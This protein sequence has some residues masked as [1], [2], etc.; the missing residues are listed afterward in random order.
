MPRPRNSATVA[1][2]ASVA[3]VFGALFA[4][5]YTI[6]T[7]AMAQQPLIPLEVRP[8]QSPASFEVIEAHGAGP[9]EIWCAAADHAR[10]NL[11]ASAPQRIYVAEPLGQSQTQTGHQKAQRAVTFTLIAPDTAP[12]QAQVFLACVWRF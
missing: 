9:S 4:L 8:A 7:P 6:G 2:V 11:G 3:T 10:R 12:D 1:P 5:F